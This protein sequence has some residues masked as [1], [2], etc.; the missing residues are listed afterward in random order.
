MNESTTKALENLRER[1]MTI[2]IN[3]EITGFKVIS[4]DKPAAEPHKQ[5]ADIVHMHEK[6]NRPDMSI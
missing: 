2:K 1:V 3:N 4:N 5:S 6:V